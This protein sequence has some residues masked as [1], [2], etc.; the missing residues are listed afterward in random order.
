MRGISEYML[1]MFV[2]YDLDLKIL[3]LTSSYDH[4]GHGNFIMCISSL[5][6]MVRGSPMVKLIDSHSDNQRLVNAEE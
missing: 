3:R 6:L 5:T 2:F 4:I 1:L